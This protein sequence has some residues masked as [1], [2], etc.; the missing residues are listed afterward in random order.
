[1]VGSTLAA[2][3]LNV[4]ELRGCGA[5]LLKGGSLPSPFSLP[6]AAAVAAATAA[7][8]ARPL[9]TITLP[10]PSTSAPSRPTATATAKLKSIYS[11]SYS[12]VSRRARDP[13]ELPTPPP[14][15]YDNKRGASRLALVTGSRS[16]VVTVTAQ[17]QHRSHRSPSPTRDKSPPHAS[18]SAARHAS[19]AS[20]FMDP[21][22]LPG[23]P[24]R[25]QFTRSSPKFPPFPE[26]TDADSSPLGAVAS[27]P[28]LPLPYHTP[29]GHRRPVMPTAVSP[30]KP[31][32]TL[33][34]AAATA[35][36]E[37][38]TIMSRGRGDHTDD[39]RSRSVA[40][41]G[42]HYSRQT[43][44]AAGHPRA[45]SKEPFAP[46]QHA[47]AGA[48]AWVPRR[49]FGQPMAGGRSP[50]RSPDKA[51]LRALPLVSAV[52][53]RHNSTFPHLR[54]C[55]YTCALHAASPYTAARGVV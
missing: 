49:T 26:R 4:G 52:Q 42:M 11:K 1:M 21:F 28:S 14:P 40:A 30:G 47:H 37:V 27:A 8:A 31:R 43:P 41:G 17:H 35:D 6:A 48:A 50:D 51:K 32:T 46:Q 15:P 45:S 29:M 3:T 23:A 25:L 9:S 19:D 34:Q 7:A 5:Q 24:Y 44:A 39:V 20:I 18:K 55:I 22:R 16:P 13:A 53:V 12:R 2:N 33:G 10:K 38:A 36:A 54:P